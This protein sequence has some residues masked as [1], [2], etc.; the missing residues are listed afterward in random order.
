M[1][2]LTDTHTLLLAHAA[3][4]ES[5]SL[6]PLPDPLVGTARAIKA[7]SALLRQGLVAE[8]ETSVT[9]E[10][11]WQDDDRRIGVFITPAGLAAIN[12]S[13]PAAVG[14][15]ASDINAATPRTTKVRTH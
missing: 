5:G 6:F 15:T 13:E 3:Q 7:V 11:V 4:R 14:E 8:Q 9:M 1:A 10:I 2:K 12:V